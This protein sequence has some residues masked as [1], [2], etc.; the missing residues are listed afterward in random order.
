MPGS[1]TVTYTPNTIIG[2][3]H[4]FNYT[5]PDRTDTDAVT[6]RIIGTQRRGPVRRPR[7]P[8]EEGRNALIWFHVLTRGRRVWS[9]AL[10]KSCCS[11]PTCRT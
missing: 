2:R 10:Q 3:A 4:S 7:H 1:A 6:V 11:N 9:D 5:L 8:G